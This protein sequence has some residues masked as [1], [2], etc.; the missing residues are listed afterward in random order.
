MLLSPSLTPFNIVYFKKS[1]LSASSIE[2][3]LYT[4]YPPPN[5]S[6]IEALTP[7]VIIFGG[8]TFEM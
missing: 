4:E 1:L 3:L 2:C 6:Y 8:G 7:N 5:Q